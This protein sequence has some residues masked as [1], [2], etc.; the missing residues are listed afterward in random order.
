[1]NTIRP[2][3]SEATRPTRRPAA[4]ETSRATAPVDAAG[5][6][7]SAAAVEGPV[8]ESSS[9]PQLRSGDPSSRRA[10]QN[11]SHSAQQ[12]QAR[13]AGPRPAG[14]GLGPGYGSLNRLG[15]ELASRDPRFG[16]ATPQT[17]AATSLALAIG[18]TEVFSKGT[19]ATDFF[20]RRGGTGMNMLGFGQFNLAYHRRATSTPE[21]YTKLMGD[22]LTGQARMPDSKSRS[23]HVVNLAA[24][25][26]RGAIRSG[27][28]LRLWMRENR[29][30]GSNWQ[31]IDDGWRRVPG[32]ADQLVTYLRG[33]A[34]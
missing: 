19:G 28:D 29:F 17:R 10:G 34:R 5:S 18:G 1:M 8:A 15:S 14:L 4:D 21:G 33:G 13:L 30:G 20:T 6:T 11:A 25:V 9:R 31:G 26:E 24:A 2:P 23:N 12:L 32:L 22:I 7:T 27:E 16:D 3:I